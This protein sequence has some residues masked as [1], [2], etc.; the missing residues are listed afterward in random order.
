MEVGNRFECHQHINII[1]ATRL[2][3]EQREKEKVFGPSCGHFQRHI[4]WE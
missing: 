4:D 3:G 2:Q 1:K